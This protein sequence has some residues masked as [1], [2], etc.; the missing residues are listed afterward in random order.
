[1]IAYVIRVANG[2][3]RSKE[4]PTMFD[5]P[6]DERNDFEPVCPH[7][8]KKLDRLIART[9][10]SSMFSKRLVYSCP[11]CHKVLGVSHRKGMLANS[12][13]YPCIGIVANSPV[14]QP[15]PLSHS[16]AADVPN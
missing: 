6:V 2:Q 11:H 5:L 7:C 16:L 9:L 3:A 4:P 8:E 12:S 1:L 15:Q 14:R 13:C 10:A